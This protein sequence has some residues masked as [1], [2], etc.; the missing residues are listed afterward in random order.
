MSTSSSG[1]APSIYRRLFSNR[2]F[3]LLWSGQA[4]STFGDAFFNLAVLWIVYSQS[5]SILQTAIVQV[6]WHLADI[7]V[8]PLAGVS[9]DRWDRK[10]IMVVT[11]LLAAGIVGVFAAI[12]S[13]Q[14]QISPVV[15]F[16]AVFCLNSLTAF[17][18]PAR[19]SVMPT[20]VGRDLLATAGG[21]FTSAGQV[22]SLAGNAL[23]GVLISTANAVWALVVDA[24]SFMFVALCIA[25]AHFPSH[26]RSPAH[27]GVSTRLPRHLSIF[28]DI[29]D[30]WRAIAT[31]P[32]AKALVWLIMLI[33]V[34]SFL[35]P[36]Y[37]ALIAERL[38]GGAAAY[39]ILQAMAVVG[40]IVGGALAGT[41][42]RRFGAGYTLISGWA[43]AGF[44]TL[45]IAAS[46]SL[47]VTIVLEAILVFGLTVGSVSL[48]AL[49]QAI[50][51]DAYLGRVG[52]IT[53]AVAVIAIP[54]STLIGAWLADILGPV[55][56]FTLGGFWILGVTSLALMNRHIRQA[57]IPSDTSLNLS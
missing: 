56:L 30:G 2:A 4:V 12:M 44:C 33:N 50:I 7:I 40:G 3:V 57:R 42:E 20:V 17:F 51:P 52:G 31:Q 47:P 34:T 26:T 41:I 49:I 9:A 13:V 45:G 29:I 16:I 21:L 8:A 35:G 55:P 25:M 1:T 19:Y 28:H 10:R 5:Q 22:A 38:G 39:G 15:I 36:L 18:V 43:S 23:A 54:L 27:T 46:V 6:V 53:R 24:V 11:N 37:P 32:I 48:S 14:G